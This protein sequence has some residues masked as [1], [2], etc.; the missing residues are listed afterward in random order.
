MSIT[1]NYTGLY[2]FA[3]T[4]DEYY[5]YTFKYL[6]TIPVQTFE[7]KLTADGM[8]AYI[9]EKSHDRKEYIEGNNKDITVYVDDTVKFINEYVNEYGGHSLAI[10]DSADADVA[11]ESLTITEYTFDTAGDYSYYCQSHTVMTGNITVIDRPTDSYDNSSGQTAYQLDIKRNVNAD[12]FI[13]AGGGGGVA[14][15][16]TSTIPGSGG[17]AGGLIFLQNLTIPA[18]TYQIKVG[19][20]GNKGISTVQIGEQGSNSSFSYLLTEAIGGG[21]GGNRYGTAEQSNGG[22]GG[23]GGGG[24]R[25]GGDVQGSA[26]SGTVSNIYKADG[27]TVILADYRQ[28]YEGGAEI[29]SLY[30]TPYAGG[31]GGAGGRGK[32]NIEN[33]DTLD[34]DG[35][36]GK[37]GED[38]IDFKTLF[39]ITNTGIGEHYDNKVYFAGGG[40]CGRTHTDGNESTGGLGGGGDG[41]SDQLDKDGKPNTGGGG[42]GS[43]SATLSNGGNGGSGIVIIRF[44]KSNLENVLTNFGRGAN[45]GQH[46]TPGL[47]VLKT[48]NNQILTTETT[49]HPK[50]PYSYVWSGKTDTATDQVLVK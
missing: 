14:A 48:D 49:K 41:H 17:G 39:G 35:G 5:L 44:S 43:K 9:F 15:A 36:I 19:K 29:N 32:N 27:T 28:G 12:I 46:A 37:S 40:A 22:S 26:G 10:K 8:T 1:P 20:G 18:D 23:S 34:G 24:N 47:L 16:G 13:V 3:D 4:D 33:P 6:D 42:A 11:T 45:A 38:T 50:L 2:T 21:G 31:G 25:A 30:D 7:Y